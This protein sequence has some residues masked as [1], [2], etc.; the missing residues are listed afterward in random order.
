MSVQDLV[1]Q[2]SMAM[3]LSHTERREVD[4]A[5]KV[6]TE[7]GELPSEMEA[8]MRVLWEERGF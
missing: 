7:A 6:L 2:L 5:A 4:R 3:F 1:A 8:R